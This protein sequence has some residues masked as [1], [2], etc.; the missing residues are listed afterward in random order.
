M[1]SCDT[2]TANRPGSE[3]GGYI[4]KVASERV[5]PR[6]LVLACD[7]AYAMP[8][9]TALRSIVEAD[10]SGRPVEVYVLSDG[11]SEYSRRKV[12]D[13]LPNG[14][15]SIRWL[16]V[17]LTM[18]RDFSTIPGISKMTFGRFLIPHILPDSVS[19]VLYLDADVLALNDLGPLWETDLEIA[20]VGAVL[21]RSVDP[22]LKGGESGLEDVPRVRAYFNAGVLLIDLDR[23][24]EERV[25]QKALEY[26]TKHP[27]SPFSD[28]DA[29]NVV[30]DGRWKE[31]DPR[32][33]FQVYRWPELDPRWKF[34]A[35]SERGR[36]D[37]GPEQ[38]PGIIHFV[39]LSKPWKASELSLHADFYDTFRSR[40][41]FARTTQER[42]W[43]TLKSV[44][45]RLKRV[46][47]RWAFLRMI[48]SHV[49]HATRR[50]VEKP[51]ET[52]SRGG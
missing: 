9:A 49:K 35:Y 47:R 38:R 29:L 12:V 5:G 17:D 27:R 52:T 6:P 46:L 40:T 30:C 39:T 18:F 7:E 37:I 23:W 10:R 28:Q 13:S 22:M 8:L 31:L 4:R 43:D 19:K 45:F 51:C 48:W 32:W 33:N 1:G 24:R 36:S 50:Q 26:L 42:L 14:S 44:W 2:P 16:A 25:S 3:L 11:F 15:A 20:V 21:D 34:Q 41:R